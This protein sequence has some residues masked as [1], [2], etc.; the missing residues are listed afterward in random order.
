MSET[1][2][3]VCLLIEARNVKSLYAQSPLWLLHK[4]NNY[5]SARCALWDVSINVVGV[6]IVIVASCMAN[7]I[8]V[9][10]ML[11]HSFKQKAHTAQYLL[12]VESDLG[13]LHSDHHSYSFTRVMWNEQLFLVDSSVVNAV[14]RCQLCWIKFLFYLIIVSRWRLESDVTNWLARL[15]ESE[16]RRLAWKNSC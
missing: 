4:R 2:N 16:E 11:V 13:G 15:S 8:S 3:W 12:G 10:S 1:R 7:D 9:N 6:A 5:S 14:F